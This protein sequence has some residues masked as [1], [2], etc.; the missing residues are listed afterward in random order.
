[1][2]GEET[3]KRLEKDEF[4]E[5]KEIGEEKTNDEVG[6]SDAQWRRNE[7]ERQVRLDQ[8]RY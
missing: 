4:Q 6:K 8:H 7:R 5:G 1:M 2:E 3:R